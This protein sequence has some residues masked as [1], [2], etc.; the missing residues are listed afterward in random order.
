[1]PCQH[2]TTQFFIG[3]IPFMPPNQQHQRTEGFA[4]KATEKVKIL[5]ICKQVYTKHNVKYMRQRQTSE[6]GEIMWTLSCN[7]N[8]EAGT[9]GLQHNIGSHQYTSAVLTV[10]WLTI[11]C[12]ITTLSFSALT[13]LVWHQ[14]KHWVM[15]C[16]CDDLSEVRCRLFLYGPADATAIPKTHH[17][18]PFKSRLVLPFWYW[19]TQVVKWV[20]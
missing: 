19:H 1:M 3:W 17:L 10:D 14:E 8:N 5:T 2:P 20:K 7:S 4:V 18:T 9:A 12:V 11:S 6:W 15:M 16:W 13:L